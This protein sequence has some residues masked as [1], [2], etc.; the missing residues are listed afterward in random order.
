VILYRGG[1]QEQAE[2]ITKVLRD[3]AR[4]RYEPG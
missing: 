1:S 2:E 3:A 4:L